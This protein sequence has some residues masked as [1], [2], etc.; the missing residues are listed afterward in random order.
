MMEVKIFRSC[1]MELTGVYNIPHD[2]KPLLLPQRAFSV[3]HVWPQKTLISFLNK[4]TDLYF[5]RKVRS[6]LFEL[7]ENGFSLFEKKS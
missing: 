2:L 5:Q 6:L 1:R 3:S 4:I 7:N